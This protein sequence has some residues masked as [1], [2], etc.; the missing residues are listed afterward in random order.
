MIGMLKTIR[1]NPKN[2]YKYL[3]KVEDYFSKTNLYGIIGHVHYENKKDNYM[4]LASAGYQGKFY[5]FDT[6][7]GK[8]LVIADMHLGIAETE[9]NI[10]DIIIPELLSKKWKE[11]IFLGDSFERIF[12]T[13][14]ELL[15]DNTGFWAWY[16]AETRPLVW[17]YGNHDI[18]LSKEKDEIRTLLLKDNVSFGEFL[19]IDGYT[20]MHGHQFDKYC[21]GFY[22]VLFQ[23]LDY[24]NLPY[25]WTMSLLAKWGF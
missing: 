22:L 7:A 12:S 21:S 13:N 5:Y 1:T 4:S 24:I 3:G 14:K 25:K 6:S 9:K 20:F 18:N 17:I 10:K 19:D 23:I 15:I 16:Y 11:V 8:T 2:M